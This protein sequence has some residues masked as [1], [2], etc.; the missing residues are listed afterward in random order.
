MKKHLICIISDNNIEFVKAIPEIQNVDD[1]DL[2]IIDDGSDYDVMDGISDYQFSKMLI[3][4]MPLG[5]G[6]HRCCIHF[7]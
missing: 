6:M 4:E 3:H 1:A 7:C 2:L 5:Y